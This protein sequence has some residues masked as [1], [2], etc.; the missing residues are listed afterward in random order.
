VAP[1]G[2]AENLA[3]QGFDIRRFARPIA[4]PRS[5]LARA[6]KVIE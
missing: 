5:L 1:C 3:C 2:S 6:D 4:I